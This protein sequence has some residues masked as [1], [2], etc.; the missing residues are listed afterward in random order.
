MILPYTLIDV[1]NFD[2]IPFFINNADIYGTK[3]RG[4]KALRYFVN[5]RG[6]IFQQNT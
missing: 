1:V 5:T 6:S 3:D 4:I 2:L